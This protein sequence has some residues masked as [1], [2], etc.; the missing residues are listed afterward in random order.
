MLWAGLYQSHL[1]PPAPRGRSLSYLCSGRYSESEETET[2]DIWNEDNILGDKDIDKGGTVKAMISI[3]VW[4]DAEGA[5][6]QRFK[7]LIGAFELKDQD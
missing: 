3:S 5:G 2:H 6:Y 1:G 4:P 7:G